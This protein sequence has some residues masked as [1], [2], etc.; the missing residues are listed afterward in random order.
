MNIRNIVKW[1]FILLGVAT[2]ITVYKTFNPNQY[3]YYPKC[4]FRE[5]TG[6]QCIGCGSQRAIHYLLNFDIIN[7]IKEN[8]LLVFSI[9]YLLLGFVFDVLQKPT[10]CI[11]IWRKRLFG[12]KA[13]YVVTIIL[14]GFWILRNY[15]ISF[16][17]ILGY[18]S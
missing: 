3:I 5:L 2:L 12:Q 6:L 1:C 15:F 17:L 9:P 8:I 11:L 16:D 10:K 7:A 14:I 13:I 18:C 4:I